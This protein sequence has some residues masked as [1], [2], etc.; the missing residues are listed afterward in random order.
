MEGAPGPVGTSE[1]YPNES[2]KREVSLRRRVTEEIERIV[3]HD[4][5]PGD[6]R[7]AGLDKRRV[8]ATCSPGPRRIPTDSHSTAPSI[9]L[10]RRPG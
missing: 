10:F 8:G 2:G 4:G 6:E 1:S 7:A 3:V 5:L 9:L